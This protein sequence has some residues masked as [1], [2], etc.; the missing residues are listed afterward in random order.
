MTKLAVLQ[1]T[2]DWASDRTRSCCS[3]VSLRGDVTL[4]VASVVGGAVSADRGIACLGA[5]LFFSRLAF[6]ELDKQRT[7]PHERFTKI[8]TPLPENRELVHELLITVAMATV[9][10]VPC[11]A[12]TPLLIVSHI[13]FI[14]CLRGSV[15]IDA[16]VFQELDKQRTSPH[17]RFT[18][19]L[20]PLPENRESWC[21]VQPPPLFSLCRTSAS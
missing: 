20:T 17:E 18:K 21:R 10:L 3:P 11:P 7:S 2:T 16:A 1:R 5:A 15:N 14:I 4:C 13:C 6:Q 12:S 19:I 8:L 9:Q